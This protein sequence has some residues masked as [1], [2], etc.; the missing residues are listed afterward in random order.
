MDH[1]FISLSHFIG[2]GCHIFIV[3]IGVNII[4]II[5]IGQSWNKKMKDI[6]MVQFCGILCGHKP[7]N[8][9]Q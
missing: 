2:S 4:V 9:P 7:R 5:T 6:V 3:I 1:L 8:G